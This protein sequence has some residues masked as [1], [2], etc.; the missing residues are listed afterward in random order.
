MQVNEIVT[1]KVI[2]ESDDDVPAA[3]ALK[4]KPFVTLGLL[5]VFMFFQNSFLKMVIE[6]CS[7]G[8]N[9]LSPHPLGPTFQQKKIPVKL[10]HKQ[11]S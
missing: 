10:V 1:V 3:A 5:N 2:D 7:T 11:K 8:V 6:A 9:N 4:I